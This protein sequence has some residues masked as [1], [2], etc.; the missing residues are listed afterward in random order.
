MTLVSAAGGTSVAAVGLAALGAVCFGLAAIRQHGA[1]RST[2]DDGST[3]GRPEDVRGA[4][5][6]VRAAT[7]ALRL[8]RQP[9]WLLGAGQAAL[10]GLLHVAAL[11]LAPVT[12]VQPVGVLAVP[13]TVVRSA[14]V[15]GRRPGRAQVAGAVLS[16]LGVTALTVVLLL[17]GTRPAVLPA[18]PG[19]ALATGA[20]VALAGALTLATR[21]A[22]A[23]PRCVGRAVAAATLFGLGSVLVRTLG[24][25][26]MTGPD[27]P[28][29]VVLGALVGLAVALPLGVWSMQSAYLAG[30]PQVVI[31]CLTLLDPVTAVVGG[32][33]L[34]GDGATVTGTSLVLAVAC[35]LV[36]AVGVVLLAREYPGEAAEA[37]V[38]R[39][40]DARPV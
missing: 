20:V 28:A 14:L 7:S 13:V 33:L 36:V 15:R 2:L 5:G 10:G 9:A 3:S 31:C 27:H 4:S 29:G 8:V 30:A 24:Q 1:V 12:L 26:V 19:L 39:P 16:V 38:G 32:R 11:A 25:V 35:G 23:L 34:L 18:W 21:R 22:P 17:P 6:L 40:Q 37:P